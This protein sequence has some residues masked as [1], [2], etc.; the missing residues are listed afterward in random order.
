[1]NSLPRPYL[2]FLGMILVPGMILGFLALKTV[3]Q[4]GKLHLQQEEQDRVEFV[5]YI[6]NHVVDRE[7]QFLEKLKSS[8]LRS[9]LSSEESKFFLMTD[10]LNSPFVSGALLWDAQQ[11]PYPADRKI[12]SINKTQSTSTFY[13]IQQLYKNGNGKECISEID[14]VLSNNTVAVGFLGSEMNIGL[15]LLRLKCAA[16]TLAP[17]EVYTDGLKTLRNLINYSSSVDYHQLQYAQSQV[18]S[19]LGQMDSLNHNQ[20]DELWDLRMRLEKYFLNSETIWKDWAEDTRLWSQ[21]RG[22]E[23]A[24]GVSVHENASNTYLLIAFPWLEN[25]SQLFIKINHQAFLSGIDSQQINM[26]GTWKQY[27]YAIYDINGALI[28]GRSDIKLKKNGHEYLITERIPQW[29]VLIDYSS[30]QASQKLAQKKTIF[31]GLLLILCVLTLV[32]GSIAVL[33]SIRSERESMRM[34]SNFLSAVTHELKTPLTSIRLFSEM[35]E[36]GLQTDPTRIHKYA[37]I[38]SKEVRRLQSIVENVLSRTRLE[39]LRFVHFIECDV[40]L[41][42]RQVLE[43][44]TTAYAEKEIRL[45]SNI[46]DTVLMV[47]HEESLR[48]IIYNLLENAIKYTPK[49]GEVKI[50]IEDH[51]NF[52]SLQITDNG[53]GIAKNQQRKIFLPFYR[54]EDELTRESKG[55][56]LGLAL[57][58]Q[59]VS[60]HFGSIHVHSEIGRGCSFTVR[61]PKHK[62]SRLQRILYRFKRG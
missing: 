37:S 15:Q 9:N 55:T 54:I 43:S 51:F 26:P 5:K 2:I 12:T 17:K 35:L 49:M 31:L 47:G 23:I 13:N 42:A 11:L 32:S 62:L 50:R 19:L 39:N 48:S 30:F 44:L 45:T 28:A 33:L 58:R 25:G 57:V 61:L 22:R 1:M 8:L 7:N 60:A 34:R 52:V 29:K 40:T 20:R 4:E 41:L 14:N 10:I 6:R 36:N 16:M 27:T 18:V 53:I 24:E 59:C 21:M 3:R 46:P 38:M 56:G